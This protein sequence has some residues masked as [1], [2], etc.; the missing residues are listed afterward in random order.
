MRIP[1]MP[2]A[3]LSEPILDY[4]SRPPTPRNVKSVSDRWLL[5]HA[6]QGNGRTFALELN[7]LAGKPHLVAAAVVLASVNAKLV[8]LHA[9][10]SDRLPAHGEASQRAA[11]FIDVG[12]MH[13]I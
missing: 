13:V 5:Q 12:P 10:F 9:P 7:V 1:E 8:L 4:A 3:Q 2:A 11:S 6:F